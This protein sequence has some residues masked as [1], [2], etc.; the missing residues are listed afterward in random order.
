MKVKLIDKKEDVIFKREEVRIE[1]EHFKT[2]TPNRQVI[3]EECA[4][5]LKTDKEL[6]ILQRIS[7][8]YGAAKCI[9]K[10]HTYKKRKELEDNEPA[11]LLKRVEKKEAPK[12]AEAPKETPKTEEKPKAEKKE[13]PAKPAE[14]PKEEV[15]KVEA[16][17]KKE[18]EK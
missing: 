2:T 4:K 7:T 10:L 9:V 12:P 15:K 8:V 17:V 16:E 18:G 1:I 11:Y 3:L 6:I 13:E 5:F 14:A